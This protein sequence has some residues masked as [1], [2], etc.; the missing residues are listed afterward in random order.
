MVGS[1][2]ACLLSLAQ[3][4]LD[5]ESGHAEVNEDS[6]WSREEGGASGRRRQTRQCAQP[7]RTKT[8]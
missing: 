4:V 1:L 3:E 5:G 6:V 8:G 2:G 7:V